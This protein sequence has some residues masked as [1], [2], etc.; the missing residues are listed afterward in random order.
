MS[1]KDW[2]RVEW[3]DLRP[4][5]IVRDIDEPWDD[6]E[7]G[8]I[9]LTFFELAGASPEDRY[10][11]SLRYKYD[12]RSKGEVQYVRMEDSLEVKHLKQVIRDA[13][14]GCVWS[15]KLTAERILRAEIERWNDE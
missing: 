8:R 6:R 11:K 14:D 5:D 4:G 13:F 3:S 10:T 1:H 15:N 9:S 2:V 12:D 7:V